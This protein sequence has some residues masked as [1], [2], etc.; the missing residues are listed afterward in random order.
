MDFKLEE[1][2]QKLIRKLEQ[3]FG[4]GIDTEAIMVLIG[5]DELGK[6]YKKF[7]KDEKVNLIHVATCTLLEPYGFYK[8]THTDDDGWPHYELVEELPPI[9]KKQKEHLMK[10]AMLNYFKNQ[11]YID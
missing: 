6:G 7:S 9:N 5:V 8:F 2:Y 3:D 4:E 1:Q 10:E 11:E